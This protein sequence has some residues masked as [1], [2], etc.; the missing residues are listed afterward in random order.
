M[1]SGMRG[2]PAV[3]TDMPGMVAT[4]L[5][6]NAVTVARRM[7][8]AAM[9][10]TAACM[11]TA[12][13]SM[14][15]R[16]DVLGSSRRIAWQRSIRTGRLCRCSGGARSFNRQSKYGQSSSKAHCQ[17]NEFGH[18]VSPKLEELLWR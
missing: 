7:G 11:T 15:C 8:S 6:M 4:T 3:M 1:M 14:G 10:V 13:R 17:G 9:T 12:R 2:V 18:A 16:L 5:G